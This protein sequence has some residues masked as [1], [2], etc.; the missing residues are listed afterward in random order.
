MKSLRTPTLALLA[1][2]ALHSCTQEQPTTTTIKT[3]Q[4]KAHQDFIETHAPN[5]T[6]LVDGSA[7]L[8]STSEDTFTFNYFDQKTYFGYRGS[9][10]VD[11]KPFGSIDTIYNAV[12]IEHPESISVGRNQPVLLL[13]LKEPI[14]ERFYSL[15][16][17]LTATSEE[18]AK[19]LRE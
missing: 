13:D 5:G 9:Q 10:F 17:Q 3:K 16:E 15:L 14:N 2:I 7:Y 8:W 19:R 6:I 4:E 12:L 11:Y 1:G 18:L